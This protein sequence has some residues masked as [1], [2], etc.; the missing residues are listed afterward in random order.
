[1]AQSEK[2]FEFTLA[3][4]K[5]IFRA[6]MDREREDTLIDMEELTEEDREA[7]DYGDYMKEVHN[8]NVNDE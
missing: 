5:D 3:Q 1:M 7:L 6:G 4:I 2:K 8:I